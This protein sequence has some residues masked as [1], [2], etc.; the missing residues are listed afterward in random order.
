M[1]QSPRVDWTEYLF[2][3]AAGVLSVTILLFSP[4]ES[5][6][7]PQ[8]TNFQPQTNHLDYDGNGIQDRTASIRG[9]ERV[10]FG[11]MKDGKLRYLPVIDMEI[12]FPEKSYSKLENDVLAS[13]K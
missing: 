3:A 2:T 9:K 1:Y 11:V 8:T 12:L 6:Q 5:R 7:K 13:L 10:L 4:A